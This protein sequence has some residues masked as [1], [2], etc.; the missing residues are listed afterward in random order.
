MEGKTTRSIM[1]FTLFL[2][3]LAGQFAAGDFLPCY[4]GCLVQCALTGTPWFVCPVTC[5][6]SCLINQA[7][8]LGTSHTNAHFCKIGCAVTK[9]SKL[10]TE[11]DPAVNKVNTCVNVCSESCLKH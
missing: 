5:A 7:T 4:P 8:I 10:S 3:V 1:I 2:V 11:G 6:A 9:C